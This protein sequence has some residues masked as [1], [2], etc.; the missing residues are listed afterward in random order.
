MVTIQE[1]QEQ[2][3]Q[4]RAAIETAAG[5]VEAQRLKLSQQQL[6]QLPR[7]QRERAEQQFQVEKGKT[8]QQIQQEKVRQEQ[9]EADF[10]KEKAAFEGAKTASEQYNTALRVYLGLQT[11]P[12]GFKEIPKDIRESAQ[13]A[14]E[15]QERSYYRGVSPG[16]DYIPLPQAFDLGRQF[17][18]ITYKTLSQLQAQLVDMYGQGF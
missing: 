18:E 17:G 14:A 1:A 16:E 6:R 7:L 9:L 15:Q 8:I 3:A 12:K 11:T 13:R 4:R 2:L 10:Q 5:T